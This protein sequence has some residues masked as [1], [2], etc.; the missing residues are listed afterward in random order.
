MKFFFRDQ[1]NAEATFKKFEATGREQILVETV[2]LHKKKHV[3]NKQDRN[4]TLPN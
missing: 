4:L 1:L 2:P 3:V